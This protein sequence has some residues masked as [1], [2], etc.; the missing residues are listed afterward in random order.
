MKS[1]RARELRADQTGLEISKLQ[2]GMK[3]INTGCT[4]NQENSPSDKNIN[5]YGEN[6]YYM[7]YPSSA[8]S[9]KQ[10]LV[11]M[12]HRM[13][14]LDSVSKSNSKNNSQRKPLENSD[15][16]ELKNP[17]DSIKALIQ[18]KNTSKSIPMSQPDN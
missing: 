12:I 16:P 6:F 5:S 14:Q 4:E 1:D 13:Y 2:S 10:A 8:K 18:R 9:D 7:N 15:F 17:S 3:R 11:D